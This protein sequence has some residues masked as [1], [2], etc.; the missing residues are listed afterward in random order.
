MD[1][2]PRV[3]SAWPCNTGAVCSSVPPCPSWGARKYYVALGHILT[4]FISR[5]HSVVAL[6]LLASDGRFG[7]QNDTS[8]LVSC[9]LFCFTLIRISLE[10]YHIEN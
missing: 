4:V 10:I 9:L 5:L 8:R 1:F 6:F 3:S 2:L 7:L